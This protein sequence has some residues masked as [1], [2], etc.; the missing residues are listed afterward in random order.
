M[1]CR[2]DLWLNGSAGY[3]VKMGRFFKSH[4]ALNNAVVQRQEPKS[5]AVSSSTGARLFGP[6]R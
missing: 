1:A 5:K 2:I 4:D 6:G 3:V